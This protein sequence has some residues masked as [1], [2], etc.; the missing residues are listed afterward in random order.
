MPQQQ[1]GRP[2]QSGGSPQQPTGASPV[3]VR[4]GAAIPA[5]AGDPGAALAPR[6]RRQSP[7]AAVTVP[8]SEEPSRP[9]PEAEP[10]PEPEESSP[11]QGIAARAGSTA[12]EEAPGSLTAAA[13]GA[14]AAGEAPSGTGTGTAEAPG[15]HVPGSPPPS[16]NPRKPMLA[17]AAIAGALLIAVPF[18]VLALSDGKKQNGALHADPANGTVLETGQPGVPGTDYVA[19]SPSASPSHTAPR[20]PAESASAT[21]GS[22]ARSSRRWWTVRPSGWRSCPRPRSTS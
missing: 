18:L 8:Q 7:D 11:D 10:G 5:V 19:E 16:A 12:D 13:A 6:G 3:A 15:T 20:C 4:H 21:A 17:A 22:P 9:G 1:P 2:G 14:D